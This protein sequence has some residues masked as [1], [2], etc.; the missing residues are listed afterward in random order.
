M[1]SSK[2][3]KILSLYHR[4]RVDIIFM[5][6]SVLRVFDVA[7]KAPKI[8]VN[9]TCRGK[10]VH[11]IEIGGLKTMMSGQ[12]IG[13]LLRAHDVPVPDHFASPSAGCSLSINKYI[14]WHVDINAD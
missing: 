10:C 2:D 7:G 12:H 4:A 13:P 11:A 3:E 6:S 5:S 8:I 9:M 14:R 1:C